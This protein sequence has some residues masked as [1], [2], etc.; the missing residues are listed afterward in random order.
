MDSGEEIPA[1]NEEWNFLGANVLEW[2]SGMAAALIASNAIFADAI[3]T[4]MPYLLGIWVFTTTSL[5]TMRKRYPDESR[6]VRNQFMT[7][8][9][10][11]PPGIPAPSALQSVWSGCPVKKMDE[12]CEFIQLGLLEIFPKFDPIAEEVESDRP[13]RRI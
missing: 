9:G 12:N 3:A 1:L 13:N 11:N 5:A 8:C 2:S 6:G 10:F 4:S 7:S